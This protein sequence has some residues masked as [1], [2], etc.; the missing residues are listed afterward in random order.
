MEEPLRGQSRRCF[1]SSHLFGLIVMNA[2]PTL[3]TA[4]V[5][6]VAPSEEQLNL[7]QTITLEVA[8]ANDL[9][10]ALEIV[11]R[12]VCQ[13]TRWTLGQGW[14]P[15]STGT[16]LKLGPGWYDC[17]GELQ[18]FKSISQ[19]LH[20]EPGT[21]LPGRV[22]QSKQPVWVEN[23]ATDSNFPRFAAALAA[24]LKTGVAIP[25]VS[26]DKVIAVLEFFMRES[27]QENEGMLNV[28]NAVAG[29][30][31]L[32]HRATQSEATERERQFRTMANSISQLAWMAD[33]EG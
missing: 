20:F 15:D 29:Q 10:A 13:K 21:G 26:G 7:L 25:I 14:L 22:W 33:H 9:S 27:R 17:D 5:F 3:A 30:L 12:R 28:I 11:L 19:S 18:N 6:Q 8:K 31:D 16:V 32:V 23:L 2:L 4:S 1:L 24:G